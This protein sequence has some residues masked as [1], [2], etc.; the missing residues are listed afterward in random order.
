VFRRSRL[1]SKNAADER[2]LFTGRVLSDV[3]AAGNQALRFPK[4]GAAIVMNCRQRVCAKK[5]EQMRGAADRHRFFRGH[6]A[7]SEV[8]QLEAEQGRV[9]GAHE[10]FADHLLDGAGKRG[11]G[12]GIPDLQE[13]GFRPVGEPIKFR[14]G[15][16]DG[17]EGV[18]T[19]DDGAF[20]DGAD[21]EG[22]ASTV[23]R[24]RG[25]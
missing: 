12:D 4:F 8:V 15:V 3:V 10:G 16:L 17:D 11:D 2:T 22:Q 21:A 5:I 18:L 14:I 1:S 7:E 9:A 13:N 25:A 23:L 20:L 24:G 19:F 6:T